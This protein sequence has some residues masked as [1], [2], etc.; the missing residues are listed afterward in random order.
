MKNYP[1]HSHVLQ[2]K[3]YF[4]MGFE[5]AENHRI[6]IWEIIETRQRGWV[7]LSWTYT[8]DDGVLAPRQNA[9]PGEFYTGRLVR[10]FDEDGIPHQTVKIFAPMGTG[11]RD[12]WHYT[13]Y[14]QT[15]EGIV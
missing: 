10:V 8:K 1:K 5:S 4:F 15:L 14:A 9:S 12:D 7:R 11:G 6:K 13:D 2:K 3:M